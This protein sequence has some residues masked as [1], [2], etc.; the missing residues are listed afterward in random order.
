MPQP[1][2]IVA[3][4]NDL[5]ALTVQRVLE[6]TFSAESIIWDTARLSQNERITFY[7]RE[8]EEP[9]H[10]E[11]DQGLVRG[12]AIQSIWW[13]RPNGF[14]ISQNAAASA[15]S[16]FNRNEYSALFHGALSSLDVPIL[17]NP[18]AE[19]RASK[20]PFQLSLA[21]GLGLNIPETIISNDPRAIRS[22]WERRSRN[23]IYK[24]LAPMQGRLLET[25]RLT[26][27][28]FD[29]I[30]KV[31][32][33]PIIVQEIVQGLD[34]RIN[35]IGHE[36]FGAEAAPTT[37]QAELDCRIDPRVKWEKHSIDEEL[38][39]DLRAFVRRLGL[40]YGS[41]DM[42]RTSEGRYV[43]FEVN[44]SGQFLFIEID[45]GHPLSDA[46]AAMLLSAGSET[47]SN[48]IGSLA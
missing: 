10:L 41:I 9:F 17:N 4:E 28:D 24:T 12:T 31:R 2:L 22:F 26:A 36:I 11:L 6:K 39:R 40:H 16:A 35:V 5:H 44:P 37:E 21:H 30:E 13:R 27:T 47:Q 7:P 18:Y 33:A 46:M 14:A 23:C 20:K 19:M 3:P 15:V 45:T 48:C 38:K 8:S 34:I 25:R 29:E 43:F 42:R 32:H 1:V